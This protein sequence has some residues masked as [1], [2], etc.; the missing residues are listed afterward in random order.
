MIKSIMHPY[1]YRARIVM[2]A[3]FIGGLDLGQAAANSEKPLPT[4][5]PVKPVPPQNNVAW[6]SSTQAVPAIATNRAA[7]VIL[8]PKPG[9][10]PRICGPR[11]Y[12]C[13][14]GNPFSYR[15]PAQGLRPM[16][17]SARG[18]PAGLNLEEQTGIITGVVPGAGSWTVTLQARNPRGGDR[19]PLK[20][21]ASDQISLTPPM[22]WNHWYAHYGRITDK[23]AREAADVMISSGMA[24]VGYSYV[25]VDDCWAIA[26]ASQDPARNGPPRNDQGKI[27]CNQNFPDMK[28]MVDYIHA[29]GLKAGIYSSPGPL[30]C[31]GYAGS[32]QHEAQDAATFAGWGFD[33]LKYDWCRYD[34]IAPK[35]TLE[36]MKAPYRLMGKALAAQPRDIH[37]NL[38]QYG[39]QNVWEWGTEVLGQSWRT[40]RDLGYE[41]D[42]VFEVALGNAAHREFQRPGSWN[43]PDYLQIGKIGKGGGLQPCPLGPD[44]QYAFMSLWCLMAAPLFYSGD[45][46]SLD[47]FTLNV[48]CNPEVIEVDQDPL[49]Q[50]AAVVN[51]SP[52]TF[53]M[54]KEMEDGTKAVGLCNAG[55]ASA[56]ITA[57]WQDAGIKGRAPVRDLWRQK[58]L[59]EFAGAYSAQVPARGVVLVR[60]GKIR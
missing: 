9:P 32:Y 29:K 54:V 28:G 10:K 46:A 20:I 40:S 34:K 51:L 6:V 15:I 42:R 3:C 14:P 56:Q 8:T 17:F 50:C 16:A 37:F 22:G 19:R 57:K 11:V 35:P 47:A 2:V 52:T 5:A 18:L 27:L 59:G 58:N 26:P 1:W 24:D 33:F 36:E 21:V 30:T 44:E 48:L 43:D 53:L 38:C 60:I 49:G 45:M 41:L 55:R 23:L 7:F 39:R 12:G 4:N 13:R 25:N 31:A